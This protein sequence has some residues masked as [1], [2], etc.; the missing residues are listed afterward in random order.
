[1]F[2]CFRDGLVTAT[3]IMVDFVTQQFEV[4]CVCLVYFESESVVLINIHNERMTTEI[5]KHKYRWHW[6]FYISLSLVLEDYRMING[7]F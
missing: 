6:L 5:C 2:G 3:S 7:I 4:M 1:M